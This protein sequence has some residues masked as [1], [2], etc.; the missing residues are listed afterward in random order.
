MQLG[1]EI[2]AS[3]DSVALPRTPARLAGLASGTASRWPDT[4]RLLSAL[5]CLQHAAAAMADAAVGGGV[6]GAV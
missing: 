6:H 2:S 5:L 1:L 4:N 3:M